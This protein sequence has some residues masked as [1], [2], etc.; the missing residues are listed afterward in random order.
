MA[1]IWISKTRSLF[2]KTPSTIIPCPDIHKSESGPLNCHLPR[3]TLEDHH[4]N[5]TEK[6]GVSI[7]GFIES[8]VL[9]Q[10]AR[11]IKAAMQCAR[12]SG[13]NSSGLFPIDPNKIPRTGLIVHFA[14]AR[15]ASWVFTEAAKVH[16]IPTN[17][18]SFNEVFSLF[19][20]GAGKARASENPRTVMTMR[21]TRDR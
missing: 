16:L 1:Q 8:S 21:N 6:R 2:F 3:G 4:N 20:G 10:E 18:Q 14:L 5:V 12:A 13:V 15:L 11:I 17:R 9:L 7:I 19:A